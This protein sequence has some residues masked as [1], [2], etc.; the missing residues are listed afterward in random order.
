M[1]TY[2]K[3]YVGGILILF[4][5][6]FYIL[7]SPMLGTEQYHIIGLAAMV[8]FAYS[9]YTWYRCSGNLFDAYIVFIVAFYVFNVSQ[10]MIEFLDSAVDH[11]RL[12]DSE[13]GLSYPTLI[14]AA[15]Y[16]LVA[17]LFFHFGAL[18]SLKKYQLK[19]RLMLSVTKD[20][21]TLSYRNLCKIRIFALVLIVVSAP[22]YVT[23]TI[24]D[25]IV[26]RLY[27]YGAIYE[28]NTNRLAEVLSDFFVPGMLILYYVSNLMKSKRLPVT[29]LALV[30]IVLPPLLIG[31]RSN[32]VI[33]MSIF[34]IIFVMSRKLNIKKVL[35]IGMAAYFLIIV[36]NMAGKVRATTG[37]GSS[38]IRDSYALLQTSDENPVIETIQEMGWSMYPLALTIDLVPARHGYMYGASYFWSMFSLVPNLGFWSIHPSRKHEAS[39]YVQ[40]K[41]GFLY[42]IGYSLIAESY[43]NLGVFGFI[44]MY[45]LGLLYT[46][47]FAFINKDS[48]YSKEILFIV[49]ILFLL[50]SIKG[51]R[52]SSLNIVRYL[53]YYILPIYLIL[54]YITRKKLNY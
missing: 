26:G 49:S 6:M 44:I 23:Q 17:L 39:A 27:G 38:A 33:V 22:F 2:T 19:Q 30:T 8:Q 4:L 51:V 16:S 31:G 18:A 48:Y 15:T 9:I 21:S 42:G 47:V 28:Q 46:K 34:G 11:R 52:N 37:S 50:F 53:F 10:P 24:Q 25:Y 36:L 1:N 41:S 45:F 14:K 12:L 20:A 5:Y 54:K 40:E 29:I 13:F 7:F 3:S 43:T 32:A 35:L